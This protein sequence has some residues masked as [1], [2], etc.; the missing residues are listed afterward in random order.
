[1]VWTIKRTDTF[2][3]TFAQ[4]RF[5]KKVIHE[6]AIFFLFL[7]RSRHDVSGGILLVNNAPMTDPEN[8]NTIRMD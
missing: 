7:V 1:M 2:L 3:E 8:E 5:D 4:V 6:L